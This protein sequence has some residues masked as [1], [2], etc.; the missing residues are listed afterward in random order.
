MEE[1]VDKVYTLAAGD[2]NGDGWAD[3]VVGTNKGNVYF[4]QNRGS[5]GWTRYQI[6]FVKKEVW[7]IALGDVDLGVLP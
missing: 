5:R 7:G 2:V 3:V 1:D 6:D 4:Y